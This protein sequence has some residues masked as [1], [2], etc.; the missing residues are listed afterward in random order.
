MKIT[1]VQINPIVGDLSKNS[2]KIKKAASDTRARNTDLIVTSELALL[3]Y[4]PRDLLLYPSFIEE[5]LGK[6]RNLAKE[7]KYLPPILVGTAI[8]N[9]SK[10]GRPL[11]NSAAFLKNG[12]VQ[13]IFYKSLLPTYDVFDEDRYFES[14][15]KPQILTLSGKKIGVS[16]C[17][18]L[19]NDNDLWQKPRY[20]NDPIKILAENKVDFIV[21]LSSSPFQTNK[22]KLREKMVSHAASKYKVPI[23]YVNQIGANDDLI[24]DGASF[25]ADQKGKIAARGKAFGEDVLIVDLDLKINNR[26][27]PYPGQTESIYSAL[28]LGVYDYVQKSNFKKV[29]IGLSGGIDSAVVTAIAVFAL[30]AEN[31]KGILMP[32]PYT[33]KSST[34]DALKL[35]E[36]L[37]IQTEEIAIEKI[38]DS[39][40]SSLERL[41]KGYKKDTTEENIQSRIRGNLLMALS[42]KYNSMLL[43]TGNKSELTVGY[44]TIYGDLTGGLAPIG[45]VLKTQVYELAN[46]VNKREEIIPESIIRKAPSAELRPNQKDQ[47]ILPPYEILDKII[48]LH[49]EGQL[50]A[51]DII[52]KGF[53]KSL[54]EDILSKIKKAEFKRRQAPPT[55]KITS[56]A[57]GTGWRMPIAASLEVI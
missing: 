35:A 1:L 24:F 48:N 42:N 36:N 33:S 22:Q 30:G 13:N 12:K 21:N 14:A 17:E 54:V 28:V 41:F 52:K 55:L 5:A 6:L 9:K 29:L 46:L 50:G 16:I 57:F 23:A 34:E 44:T 7:T 32:S 39:F 45:D 2:A 47:D 51:K 53:K 8:R 26:I 10:A 15:S 31:V 37:G 25:A 38:M 40:S 4:P 27:E 18:D 43:S 56:R 3:G 49:I 11:F 20:H 19:W